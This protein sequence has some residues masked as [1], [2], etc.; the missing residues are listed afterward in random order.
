MI[1]V[2]LCVGEEKREILGESLVDPLVAV[3]GPSNH[4]AP[5]LMS[6]FVEGYKLGVVFL[7]AGGEPGAFLSLSRQIRI[8]R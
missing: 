2:L 5:P 8:G 6:N 1:G 3:A 4:V 7:P